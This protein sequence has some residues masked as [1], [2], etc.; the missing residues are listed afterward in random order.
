MTWGRDT[1]E[2]EARALLETFLDAGGSLVDTAGSYGDGAAEE[3]LGALV[4]DLGV[5]D[6]VVLSGKS[7]VRRTADGMRRSAGRGALLDDL[8]ASLARLRTDRLDLWQ[9]QVPDDVTPAAETLSAL[10]IAVRSGRARYVG[11]SNYSGW[12]TAQLATLA[13][14]AG[15]PLAATQ[16][17]HSLLERGPEREVMPAAAA[18]GLGVIGWSSLGRGV[19]TGRYRRA[20]PADSRAASA[21]LRGFVEPYLTD[22]A[23]RVVEA[24]ATA[25]EGLGCSCAEVALAWARDAPGKTAAIIGPRTAAQLETVAD[26]VAGEEGKLPEEIRAVL[27]EVTA[28]VLGYPERR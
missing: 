12:A 14:G 20:R 1:D 27:D 8:D 4:A 16:V 9:V 19:L 28:P 7:G 13:A 2:H 15:L 6:A 21:H 10:E 25:A 3:T 26:H 5:R 18:L 23:A 11:V 17:E 22:A 24:V